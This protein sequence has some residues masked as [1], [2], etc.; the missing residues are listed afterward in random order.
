MRGAHRTQRSGVRWPF[1]AA[2][3]A[4]LLLIGAAG[5][6]FFVLR[7]GGSLPFLGDDEPEVPEFSFD[8]GKVGGVA[9]TVGETVP[10]DDL[11]G[12][13]EG[14]RETLDAMYIAGFIDPSKWEDGEYPQVLEAF[15]DRA[16]ERAR[17]NLPDLTL[18]EDSA[19]IASV[20]PL[21]GRLSVRFLVDD[22]RS[23]VS[24]VARALFSADAEATDGGPVAV[25][26]EAVYYMKPIDGRWLIVGYD[27]RG[28]VARVPEAQPEGT[29]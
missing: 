28:I 27:V 18:G 23:P 24:A 13:A 7:D 14:V 11:R 29:P 12:A 5:I 8:L 2:A 20:Q 9:V 17:R 25:Q 1:W 19:G 15:G 26:H 22:Q 16:A 6:W 4:V 3:I 10:G 21:T